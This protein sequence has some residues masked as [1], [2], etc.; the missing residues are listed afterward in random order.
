MA[1]EVLKRPEIYHTTYKK[2]QILGHI[3]FENSHGLN[4]AVEEV[5]EFLRAKNL[6]HIHT[7]PFLIDLHGETEF[8][9]EY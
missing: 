1:T 3:Y 8:D 6:K 5:K 4:S 2:G 9:R 7:V